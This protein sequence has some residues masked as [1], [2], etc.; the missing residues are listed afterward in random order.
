MN[1]LIHSIVLAT[2]VASSGL[3]SYC[4]ASIEMAYDS[5]SMIDQVSSGNDQ[6]RF[7]QKPRVEQGNE[8]P[9]ALPSSVSPITIGSS[10]IGLNATLLN[11][12]FDFQ[13][14]PNHKVYM[15]TC[16]Q[17][18]IAPAWEILKVPIFY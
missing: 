15:K 17:W 4:F 9:P 6:S 2:L 16:I 8:S 10:S 13:I 1:R 18:P 12:G 5:Q 14:S 11:R 7:P 3:T